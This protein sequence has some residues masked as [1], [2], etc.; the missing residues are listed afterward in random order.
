MPFCGRKVKADR[1]WSRIQLCQGGRRHL[2]ECFLF[3]VIGRQGC[4]D[5][6]E[7]L[8]SQD[9]GKKIDGGGGGQRGKMLLQDKPS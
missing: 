1:P 9:A 7:G 2:L 5:H 4:T 8:K 6:Q 3:A